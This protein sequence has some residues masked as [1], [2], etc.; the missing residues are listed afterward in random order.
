[1]NRRIPLIVLT[2]A[3]VLA[4]AGGL[5]A[6]L[7]AGPG[8]SPPAAKTAAI[9]DPHRDPGLPKAQ[10]ARLLRAVDAVSQD[11]PAAELA[12]EGRT[13]FRSS[14]PAFNG[15]S[16]QS[17]HTEGGSNSG[18]SPATGSTGL[19]TI[20]HESNPAQAATLGDP[21][22]GFTGLRDAPALYGVGET[23]PYGW[24]GTVPTLEAFALNA[25]ANHFNKADRT[26]QNIAALVAYMRTL[27]APTT[28]FDRGTLSAAAIR[29]QGV[30]QNQGGCI[31][32]HL[33]PNFTDGLMHNVGA[34]QPAG[35]TDSGVAPRSDGQQC[36]TPAANASPDPAALASCLFNTPGLRGV[37]HTAPYFHNGI[38]K[39]L[40]QVVNFYNGAAACGA[41]DPPALS[42]V[43]TIAPLGLTCQEASDL[44]EY[45]KSL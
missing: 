16:C 12:A 45:L 5:F 31:G 17:C 1:M 19:G 39:S 3:G 2:A 20:P 24:T 9:A 28:D 41:S 8:A 11:V 34:P 14:A 30:F 7:A 32:C 22:I 35:A 44:V 15:E 29:G 6:M 4:L 21:Q 13:I 38:A 23:D 27:Q 33:G 43:S 36:G 25:V 40:R 42:S 26:P 10:R 37:A 18:A